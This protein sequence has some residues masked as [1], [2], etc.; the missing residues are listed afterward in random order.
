MPLCILG[1]PEYLTHWGMAMFGLIRRVLAI[2]VLSG[3]FLGGYYLGRTKDSPDIIAWTV[4]A[5]H[6]TA[7]VV[8]VAMTKVGQATD[9]MSGKDDPQ[10]S[11]DS[12]RPDVDHNGRALR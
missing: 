8:E 6:K 4:D 9:G 1:P 12:D 7:Q 11:V 5:Y 3:T 2:L 10:E